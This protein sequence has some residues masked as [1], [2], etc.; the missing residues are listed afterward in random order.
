[1][2]ETKF[3]NYSCPKCLGTIGRITQTISFNRDI[4]HDFRP[5]NNDRTRVGS[6][7]YENEQRG[8][9][10]DGGDET[11]VEKTVICKKCGEKM[12][13][14]KETNP[15][16]MEE[17]K[18]DLDDANETYIYGLKLDSIKISTTHYKEI[19]QNF[20]NL[21]GFKLFDWIFT[22]NDRK[23]C[24]V[25]AGRTEIDKTDYVIRKLIG[26][27]SRM[28]DYYN[29]ESTISLGGVNAFKVIFKEKGLK[30]LSKIRR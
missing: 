11:I 8:V 22:F 19:I 3:K 26:E 15:L 7:M 12:V 27:G 10:Y 4:E 25:I 9:Y 21:K 5:N 2:A 14:N 16:I 13:Y 20:R 28:N 17:E 30:I 24:C 6:I 1:M 23:E 29:L 18:I